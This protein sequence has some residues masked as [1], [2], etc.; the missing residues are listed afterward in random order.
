MTDAVNWCYV[1]KIE[2]NRIKISF[3]SQY[4]INKGK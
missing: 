1:N 2:M 3:I 4:R